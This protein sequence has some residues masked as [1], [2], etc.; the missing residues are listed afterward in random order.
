MK[1]PIF[2][3][4]RSPYLLLAISLSFFSVPSSAACLEQSGSVL[5]CKNSCSN[6]D[7][8]K[9]ACNKGSANF[10]KTPTGGTCTVGNTRKIRGIKVSATAAVKRKQRRAAAV[11]PVST[12]KVSPK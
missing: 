4:M 9:T 10:E 8:L 6:C 12:L 2:S 3:R 11:K 7:S 5:T 1:Q